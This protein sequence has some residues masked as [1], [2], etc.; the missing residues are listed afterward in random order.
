MYDHQFS[1]LANPHIN[2][3]ATPKWSV[4]LVIAYG[5]FNLNQ[6]FVSVCVGKHTYF[7]PQRVTHK[8][9]CLV[10]VYF[11]FDHPNTG[12]VWYV[13]FKIFTLSTQRDQ[14]QYC[15]CYLSNQR[16]DCKIGQ[17][18]PFSCWQVVFEFFKKWRVSMELT[19]HPLLTK[20]TECVSIKK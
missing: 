14:M 10:T 7:T 13:W 15:A 11:H 5:H 8:V 16:I 18:F 19:I 9:G 20:P 4:S 3:Q 17:N 2:D 1:K 12:F 6:G